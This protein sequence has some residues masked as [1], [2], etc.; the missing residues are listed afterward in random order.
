MDT[1][2]KLLPTNGVELTDPSSFRRL[3]GR[4]LYLTVT[5]PNITYSVNYLSQFLQNP[6]SAH[7]DAA[8]RILRFLKGTFGHEI[9]LSSSNSPSFHGNTD[10]D[11]AGCPITRRSTTGYFVTLGNSPISWKS[12]KQTT[13]DRSSAETDYS[14]LENLTPELQC[15]LILPKHLSSS[16]QLADV[17]TKPLG[18]SQFGRLVGKL[19]VRSGSTAPT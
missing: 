15:G 18:A 17:F 4:Q 3:I 6:K 8:Q 11:W 13:V 14:A 16:D 2:L 1:H 12:K 5:R 9:F 10:S 19:G 7:K